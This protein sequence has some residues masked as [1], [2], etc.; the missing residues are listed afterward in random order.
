MQGGESTFGDNNAFTE[1][2]RQL[3]S[4]SLPKIKVQAIVYPKYE[5]KGDLGECVGKFRDWYV[6]LSIYITQQTRTSVSSLTSSIT[7]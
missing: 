6:Y 3:V 5:T 4:S 1:H 7:N 2:L